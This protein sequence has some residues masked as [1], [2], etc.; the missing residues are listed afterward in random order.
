MWGR[1]YADCTVEVQ[2]EGSEADVRRRFHDHQ[3]SVVFRLDPLACLFDYRLAFGIAVYE[4]QLRHVE[5]RQSPKGIGVER[6]PQD[7]GHEAKV[8]HCRVRSGQVYPCEVV[9]IGKGGPQ[10]ASA[11]EGL[12]QLAR[13]G[14]A[15]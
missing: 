7:L 11:L 3:G 5:E 13:L 15:P 10:L 14:V 1:R 9:A 2:E 6:L 12:L 8:A 4:F